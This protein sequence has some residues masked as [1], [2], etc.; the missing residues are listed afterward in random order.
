MRRPLIFLEHIGAQT[1]IFVAVLVLA[2]LFVD[3]L[4][5]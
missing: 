5:L 1:I 2:V 3:W 4:G